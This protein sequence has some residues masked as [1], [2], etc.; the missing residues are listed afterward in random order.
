GRSFFLATNNSTTGVDKITYGNF[1]ITPQI[2]SIV[3][4]NGHNID[5]ALDVSLRNYD[6]KTALVS[7]YEGGSSPN[8]TL[9]FDNELVIPFTDNPPSYSSQSFMRFANI[10]SNSQT[11][12]NRQPHGSIDKLGRYAAFT[13]DP[14][15]TGGNDVYLAH[16]PRLAHPTAGPMGSS[17]STVYHVDTGG[18]LSAHGSSWSTVTGTGYISG[19]ITVDSF[20]SAFFADN[21][22]RLNYYNAGNA[23]AVTNLGFP[24]CGFAVGTPSVFWQS[25]GNNGAAM[26]RCADGE[27]AATF[28][29]FP[30]GWHWVNLGHPTG[31]TIVSDP[32]LI[33]APTNSRYVGEMIG[34]DG[35]VWA[36]CNG[37]TPTW[38]DV[39]TP[40]TSGRK[41][42]GA[43]T[44]MAGAFFYYPVFAD[45]Y[46]D[47][48]S[49][50]TN[51]WTNLGQANCPVDGDYSSVYAG[52]DQYAF[53]RCSSG[54]GISIFHLNAQG[55]WSAEGQFTYTQSGLANC[56]SGYTCPTPLSQPT[57]ATD[58]TN[59]FFYVQTISGEQ[60]AVE[61][62]NGVWNTVTDLGYVRP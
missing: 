14:D 33:F 44:M 20:G 51:P 45:D 36:A 25:G 47:T 27:V 18:T 13:Q 28:Y 3:D 16:I 31:Q 48:W 62:V 26:V 10:R 35:H 9:P 19:G 55:V 15:F 57:G 2:F 5:W 34:S 52:Q 58:G 1:S 46:G 17:F 40:P 53:A 22:G 41:L 50:E 4:S 23:P 43:P 42:R 8:Y 39:G 61:R 24:P 21:A 11:N 29:A 59:A 7:V 49:L 30:Y 38:N 60:L 12:Y 54:L 6:E 37:C 32:A 56:P